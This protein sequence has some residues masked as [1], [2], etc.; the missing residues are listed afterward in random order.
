MWQGW[1][2]STRAAQGQSEHRCEATSPPGEFEAYVATVLLPAHLGE[3][4]TRTDVRSCTKSHKD[5]P[6]PVI[7]YLRLQISAMRDRVVGHVAGRL[8][9]PRR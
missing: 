7:D 6:E 9:P 4:L 3:V 5:L 1:V 2:A 8:H